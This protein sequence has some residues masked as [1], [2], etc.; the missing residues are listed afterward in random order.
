MYR[1]TKFTDVSTITSCNFTENNA[2][3]G[4]AIYLNNATSSSIYSCNFHRNK[5]VKLGGST[6][7]G[8]ASISVINSRT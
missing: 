7:L 4:G 6:A 5:D 1:I 2:I 8:Y 3:Y